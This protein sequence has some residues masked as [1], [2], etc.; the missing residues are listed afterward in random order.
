MRRRGS[1]S[2]ASRIDA[3]PWLRAALGVVFS[4]C[5]ARMTTAQ[6]Q[7]PPTCEG[8]ATAGKLRTELLPDAY[9]KYVDD[10]QYNRLNTPIVV[11]LSCSLYMLHGVDQTKGTIDVMLMH[12]MTWRD[13][14]LEYQTT[15]TGGCIPQERVTFDSDFLDEI[16]TP[17]YYYQNLVGTFGSESVSMILNKDGVVH[18]DT[19]SGLRFACSFDFRRMPFDVQDCYAR[20]ALL[21]DETL[22][23]LELDDTLDEPFYIYSDGMGGTH[24]WKILRTSAH[25]ERT[26]N[27]ETYVDLHISMERS[28]EYWVQFAMV[29]AT[30]LVVM[31]YGTF[32]IQRTAIPARATFAFVCFLSMVSLDSG[33]LA[34][35]PKLGASKSFILNYL[36]L[37]EILTALTVLEV[38]AANY[39]LH[40]EL[41]VSDALQIV[42]TKKLRGETFDAQAFVRARAGKIA[43]F[44]IKPNGRMR[45]SDQHVDIFARIVYPIVC[46]CAFSAIA[47]VAFQ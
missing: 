37:S 12:R 11:K 18:M 5:V 14:R 1:T 32:W 41:R 21:Q 22:I 33:T 46:L 19:R 39:M 34:Q 24:E 10:A 16:W 25:M 38:V 17:A 42:E 47:G 6:P 36:C 9:D 23:K 20:V 30:F 2:R 45:F 28:H 40:V 27:N 15:E 7:D 8:P 31:S 35:L 43:W 4:L 44:I 29:P 26:E 13:T 3:S